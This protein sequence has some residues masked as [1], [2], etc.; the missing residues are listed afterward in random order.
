MGYDGYFRSVFIGKKTGNARYMYGF[1]DVY[2][3]HWVPQPLTVQTYWNFK[4]VG[5]VLI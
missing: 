3:V 5:S 4:F 2:E 1:F